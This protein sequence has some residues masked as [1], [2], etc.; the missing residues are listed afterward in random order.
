VPRPSSHTNT[1]EYCLTPAHKWQYKPE[2]IITEQYV[3]IISLIKSSWIAL[4]NN[5]VKFQTITKY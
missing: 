4:Y 3:T 1:P 2:Q 5:N